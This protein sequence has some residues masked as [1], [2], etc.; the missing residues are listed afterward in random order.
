[1]FRR[2]TLRFRQ[3]VNTSVRRAIERLWRE[4]ISEIVVGDLK[5]I[6]ASVNG[7]RKSNTMVHNFWSHRHLMQR[8][9]EVAE[10]YGIS[11]ETVN[12]SG[13]SSRCPWCGSGEVV[14]CGSW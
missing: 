6:R 13:T 14:K 1:M 7:G 5:D 10:E 4:G 9:R 3:Y 2:R 8:V 11:V 12:E